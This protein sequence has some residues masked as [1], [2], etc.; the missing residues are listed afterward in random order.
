MGM[1]MG[2]GDHSMLPRSQRSRKAGARGVV[3]S[4]QTASCTPRL[5]LAEA[6]H[7]L[8]KPP[9]PALVPP[10][11]AL[12]G[13]LGDETWRADAF[14][15]RRVAIGCLEPEIQ[16]ALRRRHLAERNEQREAATRGFFAQ[17]TGEG[18]GSAIAPGGAPWSALLPGVC[19]SIRSALGP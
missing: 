2:T 9:L 18:G 8:S 1:S 19:V 3:A 11:T 4:R 6:R 16:Q 14:A 17:M 15:A 12:L 13:V 7:E 5:I 10:D